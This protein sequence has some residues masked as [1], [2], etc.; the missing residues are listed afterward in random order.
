M[1]WTLKKNICFVN[2]RKKYVYSLKGDNP[3]R[4]CGLRWKNC[5]AYLLVLLFRFDIISYPLQM[6]CTYP[7]F[8]L[9]CFF[10]IVCLQWMNCTACSW[11][12]WILLFL[13]G[14]SFSFC[15]YLIFLKRVFYCCFW[16]CTEVRVYSAILW[17]S[18][19]SNERHGGRGRRDCPAPFYWHES[20]MHLK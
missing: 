14:K 6:T 7:L 12:S 1:R 2:L 15:F 13:F 17:N 3:D 11:F 10:C 20:K 9:H 19:M 5:I 18:D 16:F 4:V 8:W